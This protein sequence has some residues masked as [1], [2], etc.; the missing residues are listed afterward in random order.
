VNR[1]AR[2][3]VS[4]LLL[5]I[6]AGTPI[7]GE[8]GDDAFANL[9]QQIQVDAAAANESDVLKL[10]G[11][12]GDNQRAIE[13]SVA[14]DAFLAANFSPSP[15][16]LLAAARNAVNAGS[17]RQA[18]ERYGQYLGRATPDGESAKV[19][20]E[21]LH[22]LVDLLSEDN[23]AYTFLTRSEFRFR[24]DPSVRRFDTWFLG[25]AVQRNDLPVLVKALEAM[26][27][28]QVDQTQARLYYR[29]AFVRAVSDLHKGA[30]KDTVA[31]IKSVA[32]KIPGD[33]SDK[34]RWDFLIAAAERGL[35]G[36][37][38]DTGL[39]ALMKKG[40]AYAAA[41]TNS[42][43]LRR[44]AEELGRVWQ[45]KGK[46]SWNWDV[47]KEQGTAKRKLLI[48][49]WKGLGADEQD[50][51]FRQRFGNDP[52]VRRLGSPR[53]WYAAG[54]RDVRFFSQ[55]SSFRYSEAFSD[56]SDELKATLAEMGKTV[57]DNQSAYGAVIRSLNAGGDL[58]AVADHFFGKE[59]GLFSSYDCW[60][61]WRETIE[62]A[63]R[64]IK[65]GDDKK[66]REQAFSRTDWLAAVADPWLSRSPII[67]VDRGAMYSYLDGIFNADRAGFA[68]R[69]DALRWMPLTKEVRDRGV[70]D[71][72]NRSFG[73]W[74]GWVQK[75]SSNPK[76]KSH[77]DAKKQVSLVGPINA[78][79]DRL[80][81]PD[82]T[83]P[84]LAPD[85]MTGAWA[86][87][88]V[89]ISA[90]DW[91][92][93][94]KA[95]REV[96]KGLSQGK[97]Q[98]FARMFFERL[99]R[100]GGVKK[101]AFDGQL[102]VLEAG[103]SNWSGESWGFQGNLLNGFISSRREWPDRTRTDQRDLVLKLNAVIT[104]AL[105]AQSKGGKVHPNLVT[106]FLQ[107]RRGRDWRDVN[108]GQDLMA[109][110]IES[111]QIFDSKMRHRDFRSTTAS[112]MQT[113]RQE[114]PGLAE[115]F[116]VETW[117]DQ[118]FIDESKAIAYF[119]PKYW[120]YGRDKQGLVRKAAAAVFGSAAVPALRGTADGAP[121]SNDVLSNW[122]VRAFVGGGSAVSLDDV[123]KMEAGFDK[124][125]DSWS[126]GRAYFR[127]V[128]E[129]GD[130]ATSQGAYRERLAAYVTRS[131]SLPSRGVGPDLH[132]YGKLPKDQYTTDDVKV[133]TS[134]FRDLKPGSWPSR[135]GVETAVQR[136]V[137]IH[138]DQGNHGD[139]L[140]VMPE[141][142]RIAEVLNNRTLA[143]VLLGTVKRYLKE[144]NDE[145]VGAIAGAGLDIVK[146]SLDEAQRR[147]LEAA[148]NKARS[149][150]GP[151]LSIAETDPRYPA[152]AAQRNWQ[153]GRTTGAWDFYSQAGTRDLVRDLVGELNLDFLIWAVNEHTR[154]EQFDDGDLLCR[155]ILSWMDELDIPIPADKRA[156][157]LLA[158]AKIAMQRRSYPVARAQLRY[159]AEGEEFAATKQA[160]VADLLTTEVDR[161]TNRPDEA[162][163][164]LQVLARSKDT[165][166][167]AQALFYTAK[168]RA[169]Q[170]QYEE[171]KDLLEQAMEIE[172]D[173]EM[174]F[175]LKQL[176]LQLRDLLSAKSWLVDS[177]GRDKIV[178]DRPLEISV[179]DRNS[180]M[181]KNFSS[182]QLRVWT[183]IT[184]DEEFL[185]LNQ[186]DDAGEL[187]MGDLPTEMGPGTPGDGRIQ[188]VGGD[189][190][191][192]DLS[193]EFISRTNYVRTQP[194]EVVLRVLSDAD[195]YA[196]SGR[197]LSE[198]EIQRQ[199]MEEV[200]AQVT[201]LRT[202]GDDEEDTPLS[203]RR[204]ENQVRPGNPIN[205]QVTDF[206]RN[207][208]DGPDSITV[209]VESS[210]GD[211]IG[212]FEL[213]ET[214][215]HSGKFQ[216]SIP[217]DRLPAKAYASDSAAGSDPNVV[218]SPS[219]DLP[220]WSGAT[221]QQ[222]LR[223]FGVDFNDLVDLGKMHVRGGVP[224][225]KVTRLVV[226]TSLN[227]HDFKTV[228]AWPDQISAW[229]GSLD[230]IVVPVAAGTAFTDHASL[231]NYLDVMAVD[232]RFKAQR[233]TP[234]GEGFGI[235]W[236]DLEG[237]WDKLGEKLPKVPA[238]VGDA[239]RRSRGGGSTAAQDS[240]LVRVRGV[241]WVSERQSMSFFKMRT[242]MAQEAIA[243]LAES[244]GGRRGPDVGGTRLFI[245]G[246]ELLPPVLARGAEAPS[247]PPELTMEL[248]KGLHEIE[249]I[250]L[251]PK[252][253]GKAVDTVLKTKVP[254]PPY[255][256]PV[257][258]DFF[259]L[260]DNAD[261]L[262]RW[263]ETPV[264]VTYDA[265]TNAHTVDL[266]GQASRVVRL[267]ML[268][269][270][271][272]APA[273]SKIDLGDADGEK[274]LPM[275]KDFDELR[276]N[277]ILEVGPGDRISV[278]YADPTPFSPASDQHEAYLSANF[279]NASLT[280]SFAIFKEDGKQ[281]SES[282]A[283]LRRFEIGDAVRVVITDYDADI[284]AEVDSVSFTVTTSS[285]QKLELTAPETEEHSGT[286]VGTFFPV[287]GDPGR[288][289]ELKVEV[290]DDVVVTYRDQE[291]TDPGIPWDRQAIVEQVVWS[292]PEVRV[293][294]TK[295]EELPEDEQAAL[296]AQMEARRAA[297][298][299]KDSREITGPLE[300]PRYRLISERPEE[301]VPVGA[302]P[303]QP[304]T[305]TM[306]TGL[307]VEVVWPTVAKS[308][309]SNVSIF[310]QTKNGR[311]IADVD[312]A[313]DYF[314]VEVPGTIELKA[315]PSFAAK[316]GALPP[317][318]ADAVQVGTQPIGAPIDVGS[319][320]VNIPVQLGS[321]PNES[322]VGKPDLTADQQK[323]L[324]SA[325]DE[326]YIGFRYEDQNGEEQWMTQRVVLGGASLFN[327]YDR[328]FQEVLS[329][330][331]VGETAYFRVTDPLADRT[332]EKDRIMLKVSTESGAERSIELVETLSHSGVFQSLAPFS[333]NEDK[334]AG[335]Q[336][337]AV[338]VAYGDVVTFSYSS[339]EYT[340]ER[341][342]QIERGADGSVVPFTKRFRDP[343][344]AMSTMFST[345][346][347]YFELAKQHRT[348]AQEAEA[349]KDERNA[350]RLGRMVRESIDSGR[351]I[352]EE[353]IRDFPDTELRAQAD[354][355]LAELDL[356]FA[357]ETVNEDEQR[358]FYESALGRFSNIIAN[359]SDSEYAP[360]AQYK[361]AL[362]YEEM[363]EMDSASSE[364]VKLSFRYP[365]HELVAD[366]LTR[367]GAYFQGRGTKLFKDAEAI[368]ESDPV[369]S[370]TLNQESR[371]L[372]VTGGNVFSKLRERFPE[373]ELAAQATVAAG[374]C[375]KWGGKYELAIAELE[376]VT[377]DVALDAPM[378]KSE[379]LY[380]LGDAYIAMNTARLTPKGVDAVGRAKLAL[381]RCSIDF[382][383]TIWAKRSR[384]LLASMSGKKK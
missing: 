23:N 238:A 219:E 206:D 127:R 37:K 373:H 43:A 252:A 332:D 188:V 304:A 76:D 278:S 271:G 160:I 151:V 338:P 309:A 161:L 39:D 83:D 310:A 337:N 53:D 210:S 12:A 38:G 172:S 133:L 122:M 49:A 330:F 132:A 240:V 57:G 361:R 113:V 2:T 153:I 159:I 359:Y 114:F 344:I 352:L 331:Y 6:A 233:F 215:A 261:D 263:A 341:V 319:F 258:G 192:Y 384:G 27:S 94:D 340:T 236:S 300:A 343:D 44:V 350:A 281:V 321:T 131:A 97:S 198:E 260:S 50:R 68:K 227:D 229:D 189:K 170:E 363:G 349:K 211:S 354:Y 208:T 65:G 163:S 284:S 216:G 101:Q 262:A 63:F 116:P 47:F 14:V 150:V 267:W 130:G 184:G 22:L 266:S 19:A 224:E 302:M 135:A 320:A 162:L 376:T 383:D 4:G 339:G 286:F 280:P 36:A 139:L 60:R 165:Y 152:Y 110:L 147:D 148:A 378:V 79:L 26:V 329:D 374:V 223:F 203:Q 40:Q 365:D 356:E 371:E 287:E 111:G 109:K 144:E 8:E 164:R 9:A 187:F 177:E 46:G 379:A 173:L 259:D 178:P 360:K 194:T 230:G 333:H 306:G 121:Y 253:A 197:I 93:A 293:F 169:D 353:A 325:D 335:E 34:A 89:A 62:P 273:I 241:F 175:F 355:L 134:L 29:P 195:L 66:A 126:A 283:S 243:A 212:S 221:G 228:G 299:E 67:A 297:D 18:V 16:L 74:R 105:E 70:R 45:G 73:R 314:D 264:G 328:D 69:V 250:A 257:P 369:R 42:D 176:Q 138:A 270:E 346:E 183:E 136:V 317:G 78:A 364:Y 15:S 298:S 72:I 91:P 33:K 174:T 71:W 231:V 7:F 143:A 242:A 382:P 123:A 182:I 185:T 272:G 88:L 11:L 245:D 191:H 128:G 205:L 313:D 362:V 275:D 202:G 156:D 269:Y 85:A 104:K 292:D 171:A 377:T 77:E 98:P 347:A 274:V 154:R 52:M 312:P 96:A 375:Y 28:G 348:L 5:A 204:P 129:F 307:S 100:N 336:L 327:V 358:A 213:V 201:G 41:S 311:I 381:Q 222:G 200:Y 64:L 86:T 54:A 13:A 31:A 142:W 380:W 305:H 235:N 103:L 209:R 294:S 315:G 157:V 248:A 326:I 180:V 145:M 102:A 149:A 146:R 10:L 120:D 193:D 296:L 1:L 75:A 234:S 107:T 125:Q 279:N 289:S 21:Y 251:V 24:D 112:V 35:S 30:D 249:L 80:S 334:Q 277:Q 225:Q 87:A 84:K 295:T 108:S 90:N 81:G 51:F 345:A 220:V 322:M 367:L 179:Q 199:R 140:A 351:R 303:E 190:I 357:K 59:S 158:R 232:P 186:A 244:A 370:A 61:L 276:R 115:K 119:D 167:R 247:G 372:F 55:W 256:V 17:P 255:V 214:G 20:G 25:Q 48:E 366:A 166:T 141:A 288:E 316:G 99:L 58:K 124:R 217:T 207:Q 237:V 168:V 226:Q 324:V 92:A 239:N 181:S 342:I 32:G 106:R 285:G 95:M 254:E 282:Y 323:L 196:T 265:G 291:N 290:G 301:S 318:Y 137:E 218:I 368:A 118:R 3:C 56:K 268:D 155:A 117:F 308:S 246:K 82:G